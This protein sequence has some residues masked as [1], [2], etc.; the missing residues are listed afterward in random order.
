L[1]GYGLFINSLTYTAFKLLKNEESAKNLGISINQPTH[2][3]AISKKVLHEG[4]SIESKPYYALWSYKVYSSDRFDLL[5][6]SIAILSGLASLKKAQNLVKWIEAECESMN[7]TKDLAPDLTPNFF[8]FIQ[9]EDEDWKIR[10]YDYNMPGDYHNGGIWP[11]ISGFYIAAL[12]A[13]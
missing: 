12:V 7:R 13:T 9:P 2:A 3:S 11:F 6:N 4:L 10:Y 8:P 1:L 5:G